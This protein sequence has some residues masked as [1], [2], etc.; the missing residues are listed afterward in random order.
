MKRIVVFIL[1]GLIFDISAG[2]PVS[3]AKAT[4]DIAIHF[5]SEAFGV[6]KRDHELKT[7]RAKF[8]SD[9]SENFQKIEGAFKNNK[10]D[11]GSLRQRLSDQAS[12]TDGRF[13]GYDTKIDNIG[14]R[15]ETTRSDI[16]KRADEQDKRHSNLESQVAHLKVGL[17]SVAVI[18][19]AA[20]GYSV[21]NSSDGHKNVER[22]LPMNQMTTV[23]GK[24]LKCKNELIEDFNK[25]KKMECDLIQKM[26]SDL[27]LDYKKM[28]SA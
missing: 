5:F 22:K 23:F 4:S 15:L 13:Q 24:L 20:I 9:L 21:Y 25:E 17:A 27:E 12:E 10:T 2:E 8:E 16:D 18:A 19:V 14:S 6:H 7:M 11:Y 28:I 3:W 1:V 26:Y